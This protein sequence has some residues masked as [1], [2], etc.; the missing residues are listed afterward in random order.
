MHAFWLLESQRCLH[1]IHEYT[2]RRGLFRPSLRLKHRT[3]T[4]QHR[5]LLS[6]LLSWH[7]LWRWLLA[8]LLPY[9]L[10]SVSST[11][12]ADAVNASLGQLAPP[13]VGVY[14]SKGLPQELY[15]KLRAET[16][17]RHLP[18]AAIAETWLEADS[19]DVALVVKQLNDTPYTGQIIVYYNSMHHVRE[20]R[21]VMTILND[22]EEQLVMRNLNTISLEEDLGNPLKIKKQDTFDGLLLLGK[23]VDNTKGVV[24]NVFNFL[25][26]LLVMWL[27]RQLILRISIYAPRAFWR[28]LSMAIWGT[29]LGTVLVFW[30]V[31]VGLDLEQ[32]GFIKRIIVSI[33][34]LITVE[35]LWRILVL[36]V[37]TWLFILGLLGSLT[38]GSR[39]RIDA[40]G[41]TFWATV[42]IHVLAICSFVGASTMKGWMLWVPI[43]NV[44]QLGQLNLRGL[45]EPSDWWLAVAVTSGWALLFLLLW[46]ALLLGKNVDAYDEKVL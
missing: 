32:T 39:T 34:E 8:F 31:K 7:L 24:S 37:P 43:V 19:L 30:G 16:S 23:V 9:F 25:L 28:N 13:R 1:T 46:R 35:Y 10:F 42:G 17:Y 21:A 6:I 4:T 44:F 40:Y 45:M 29:A 22:F 12:A 5:S 2:P 33:Q 41:R 3:M 20:I 14:N 18:D 26:I 38:M 27:A 15:N 36:W 11:L